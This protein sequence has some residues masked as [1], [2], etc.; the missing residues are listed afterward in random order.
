MNRDEATSALVADADEGVRL[1]LNESLMCRSHL[2][3]S[4]TR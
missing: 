3:E 2:Y 4:S 1:A